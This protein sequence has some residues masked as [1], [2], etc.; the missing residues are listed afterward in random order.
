MIF[1]IFY[2]HVNDNLHNPI[3]LQIFI[4]FSLFKTVHIFA[5]PVCFQVFKL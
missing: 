4:Q 3:S 1:K 5:I 2:F